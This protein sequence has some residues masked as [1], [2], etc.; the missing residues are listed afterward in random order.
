MTPAKENANRSMIMVPAKSMIP[1]LVKRPSKN[2]SP[3]EHTYPD[4]IILVTPPQVSPCRMTASA[5]P[6][7]EAMITPG[8]IGNFINTSANITT[9]GISVSTVRLNPWAREFIRL[10]AVWTWAVLIV[11]FIPIKK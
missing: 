8:N 10:S 1:P 9:R 4:H 11:I 3:V 7:S 2:W 5:I 6:I